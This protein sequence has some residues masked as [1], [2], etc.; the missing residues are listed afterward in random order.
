VKSV[1]TMALVGES[2]RA[3]ALFVGDADYAETRGLKR[4]PRYLA[5]HASLIAPS[6]GLRSSRPPVKG[7]WPQPLG[8]LRSAA[9]RPLTR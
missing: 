7:L 8:T 5:G 6:T 3:T 1:R 9:P 2:G 4:V